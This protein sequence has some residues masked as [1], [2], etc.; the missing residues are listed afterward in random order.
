MGIQTTSQR[1][2]FSRLRQ[3]LL[4]LA[5]EVFEADF[6]RFIKAR[7]YLDQ[8][9][10]T[11]HMPWKKEDVSFWFYVAG[12]FSMRLHGVHVFDAF[13]MVVRCGGMLQAF[14]PKAGLLSFSGR[15]GGSEQRP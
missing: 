3:T 9:A 10:E 13:P 2:R 1:E 15:E 8:L 4:H 5:S 12:N 14:G 6:F 7:A 11:Y